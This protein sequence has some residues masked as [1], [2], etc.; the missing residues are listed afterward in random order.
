MPCCL[1]IPALLLSTSETLWSVSINSFSSFLCPPLG[2]LVCLYY[3]VFYVLTFFWEV[4]PSLACRPGVAVTLWIIFLFCSRSA[5]G[6]VSH[7]VNVCATVYGRSG[8][9]VIMLCVRDRGRTVQGSSASCST[10][11]TNVLTGLICSSCRV[12]WD[13]ANGL[14]MEETVLVFDCCLGRQQ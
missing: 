2:H 13:G 10:L 9:A 11:S 4:P 7:R 14:K 5:R 1:L 3:C 12:G 6:S 8:L